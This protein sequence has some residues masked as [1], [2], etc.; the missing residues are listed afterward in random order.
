MKKFRIVYIIA[1]LMCGL[2]AC[3]YL[4]MPLSENSI[5][6]RHITL[7]MVGAVYWQE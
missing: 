5:N 2:H 4:L 7:A 1:I 3:T 6:Q